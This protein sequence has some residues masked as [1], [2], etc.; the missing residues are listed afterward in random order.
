MGTTAGTSTLRSLLPALIGIPVVVAVGTQVGIVRPSPLSLLAL[1]LGFIT[2]VTLRLG[3]HQLVWIML[4]YALWSPILHLAFQFPLRVGLAT[5]ITGIF[6]MSLLAFS[7]WGMGLRRLTEPADVIRLTGVA[8]L[9]A[10][11]VPSLAS[12]AATQFQTPP[13]F[14]PSGTRTM[15][16]AAAGIIIAGSLP[17]TFQAPHSWRPTRRTLELLA[18]IAI[19]ATLMWAITGNDVQ[20]TLG[21]TPLF[22]LV[23]ALGWAAARFGPF[24][25]SALLNGIAVWLAFITVR[26]IGLFAED[27]DPVHALVVAQTYLLV[28]GLGV[29]MLAV[30]AQRVHIQDVEAGQS[31][32]ILYSALDGAGAQLFL[33]RYD[34]DTDRFVYV[35]ANDA[36]AD[37]LGLQ[38][39]DF[40]G[41]SAEDLYEPDL[42]RRFRE[43]DGHVLTTGERLRFDNTLTVNG[44]VTAHMTTQFPLRD[45]HGEIVGVGGV[46]LDRT[47]EIRRER[48]LQLVFSHSP[49]P[50]ARLRWTGTNYGR[51]LEVNE[52]FGRLLNLS[53][54]HMVGRHLTDV[55][56]FLELPGPTAFID[57]T[58]QHEVHVRRHDGVEL[59]VRV[60]SSLVDADEAGDPFVIAL[61]QDITDA[62]AAEAGLVHRA[63]HDPL[64]DLFNRQALVERL[65]H[66]APGTTRIPAGVALLCCDIDGFKHINDTFGHDTGDRVLLAMAERIRTAA[67]LDATVARLGGDEFVIVTSGHPAA[68]QV[69]DV[70]E[71]IR[72]TVA[73]PLTMDGRRH[74]MQVS[75]GVAISNGDCGAEELLRQGDVAL[76]RA[77]DLGRDRVVVYQTAL[78]RRVQMRMAMR[79]TLS[80]ALSE[81]R[82]EA[83]LQPV[84][85]LVTGAT[86][87]AEA[88]VRLRDLDGTLLPPAAFIPVA[89]ETGLIA[90]LGLR[91]LDIGLA[92][93]RRWSDAG[94]QLGI[95]IN[96]SPRQLSDASLPA[97]VDSLLK[98]HGVAP[99][100]VTLEVTE[101]SVVDAV[102]NTLNVL[103]ELRDSGLHIAIDDF[104]TGY[105]SLSSLRHMPADIVK[106]DRSFVSGLG[107]QDSDEAIV[108][109]VLAMAHATDRI[110]VAEGVE[111][112][113]QAARLTELGCDQVQGFLFSPPVPAMDFDPLRRFPMPGSPQA[114]IGQP[115][116]G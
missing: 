56:T 102:G 20:S 36:L 24:V 29:L 30:Y 61:V 27:G 3:R 35:D 92:L 98:T 108:R 50:T 28:T 75:I 106:I 70:A 85:D 105:S 94:M 49:V 41:K 82:V 111:T 9:A 21:S 51:L 26:G 74:E 38:P 4:W 11:L 80:K 8:V 91:V 13:A 39:S 95:S 12:L 1:G 113:Q 37:K 43:Q 18:L 58:A 68:G 60:T 15:L 93:S 64:T 116:P 10:V 115:R 48:L 109:A 7:G 52:A 112:Q 76:S 45:E 23:L 73:A 31:A 19:T 44:R 71:H 59:T 101:S 100:D 57:G 107:G 33:K 104:G 25:T 86:V 67:G 2:G 34:A 83:H 40:I 87:G 32:E 6:A 110:V 16:A 78:D 46:S 84:V 17:L 114:R 63:T 81:N 5:T 89:E 97:T 62:R 65:S 99:A 47:E 69:T 14:T 55:V 54:E 88:L 90:A 53:P 96:V 22:L 79:E 66:A 77:K 72:R 103:R 42:A